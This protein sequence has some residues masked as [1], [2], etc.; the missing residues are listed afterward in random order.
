MREGEGVCRGVDLGNDGDALPERLFLELA[1]SLVRIITVLR[2]QSGEGFALDPEARRGLGP[3]VLE[4]LLHAVV[5]Q[6][7]LEGVHLVV[8]EHPDEVFEV[9]E[10]EILAGHVEHKATHRESGVVDHRSAGQRERLSG[11]LKERLRGPDNSLGLV[12]AHLDVPADRDGIA[13]GVVRAALSGGDA[14]RDDAGSGPVLTRRN[15]LRGEAQQLPAF[16]GETFGDGRGRLVMG[17]DRGRREREMAA[18]A[19]PADDLGDDER[20]GVPGRSRQRAEQGTEGYSKFSL[21][22]VSVLG[23]IRVVFRS[24]RSRVC[25]H[26]Y[27]PRGTWKQPFHLPPLRSI[28]TSPRRLR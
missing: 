4:E 25:Q 10:V 16:G 2:G 24:I 27:S 13:F 14:Q 17:D 3:V 6:V 12:G 20:F 1:E 21:H 9:G 7:D 11:Q 18:A 15:H 26:W 8:G 28:S 22:K 19:F 5:V 23:I